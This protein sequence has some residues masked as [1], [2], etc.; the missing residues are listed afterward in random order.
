[1]AKPILKLFQPSGILII[2]VSSHPCTD[3]QFQA[4]PFSGVLN[5]P[6]LGKIWW[7][8]TEI[9]AYRGNSARWGHSYYRTSTGSQM[10]SIA[11]WH[12]QWPWRTPNPVFNHSIFE[13]EYLKYCAF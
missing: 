6:G 11:R 10:R 9:S 8:S 4:N 7:F 2:P 12:F 3:I 13:V 1:M 5:T